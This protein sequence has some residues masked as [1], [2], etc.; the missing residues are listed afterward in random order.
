LENGG[1]GR[2]TSSEDKYHSR[3]DRKLSLALENTFTA[4]DDVTVALR[5][6]MIGASQFPLWRDNPT[7]ILGGRVDGAVFHRNER[8]E[9]S[10]AW[11]FVK[12]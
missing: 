9:N 7:Y 8:N 11:R 12:T 2:Q 1:S 4:A 3:R 10:A 5:C 6:S